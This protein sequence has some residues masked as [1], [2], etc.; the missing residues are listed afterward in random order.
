[1]SSLLWIISFLLHMIALLAIYKLLQQIQVLKQRPAS[2]SNIDSKLKHYIEEIRQE[3]QNLQALIQK[4]ATPDQKQQ[5]NGVL[6]EFNLQEEPFSE[7][8]KENFSSE[9]A[10]DTV[11]AS[12]EARVLQLYNQGKTIDEIASELECGKTEAEIIIKL[13]QKNV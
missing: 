5:S 10:E 12:L 1:M 7:Q 11:E 4:G 6:E 9:D 2:E 13:H 3:N 8:I